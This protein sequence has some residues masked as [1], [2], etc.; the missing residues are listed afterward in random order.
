MLGFNIN[1][2]RKWALKFATLV[3]VMG[4]AIFSNQCKQ[5]E[6]DVSDP[7]FDSLVSK[8]KADLKS[9]ADSALKS[10]KS[11]NDFAL[12]KNNSAQQIEAAFLRGKAFELSGNNDSA[13]GY[14]FSMKGYAQRTQDTAQLLS[15]YNAIG[16]LY[17]EMGSNDTVAYWLNIGLRLAE[18]AGD[19]V[20]QACFS[21]NIGLYQMKNNQLDSAMHAFTRAA[22]FFEKLHDSA[23]IAL[24]YRN[25]GTTLNS[26]KLARKA[27]PFFK[28]AVQI[29]KKRGN[30][31]EVAAEY[32]NM[33]IAYKLID[34]D[35]VK[36]FYQQ[37]M[38]L[39][40]ESGSISNLM[41]IKFNYANYLKRQ[42]KIAEAEKLYKEVLRISTDNHILM[43]QLYGLNLLAKTAV[44]RNDAATANEYFD[45]ALALAQNN[46]LT[47]EILRLY[48]D[49]FEGSLSLRNV[50]KAT[51]YF[52]LWNNLNDSLQTTAQQDAVVKYQTL[53][54]T[55][56]KNLEIRYLETEREKRRIRTNYLYS[57]FLVSLLA[58]IAS[59]YAL[60]LKGKNTGQK[61][62]IAGQTHKTLQLEIA[63]KELLLV[64]K[65][66]EQAIA[67]KEAE[68]NQKLV[69]SKM[70][71]I[72][73]NSEFLS[74]ILT[75]LQALNFK[76]DTEVQQESMK[77]ILSSIK[78]QVHTKRW[79]DFQQQYLEAHKDF[80]AKLNETHPGLTSGEHRLCAMLR[81]NLSIKEISEL[82]MQNHRAVEMAR[83]RLRNKFNLEREEN[84]VAYL[85]QF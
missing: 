9:D 41:M 83:H 37:A 28:Q 18:L 70:L 60:W 31:I 84:L 38:K 44:I 55:E 73:H 52:N 21:S 27:I 43:G 57:I 82:T 2:K 63:N 54:E 11:L 4:M 47:G 1:P 76:L 45:R 49:I 22:L 26:Q 85:S 79:D 7:V 75:E 23:N 59:M 8:V 74:A 5:P 71:I 40:D 6:K 69:V 25:I 50:E 16:N 80:F 42:G 39:L 29:N 78:C 46:K 12:S 14:Y 34:E 30:N 58:A 72:S 35:S 81:M 77:K 33:A 66:Q 19:S 13:L 10:S 3:F 36:F 53:Y 15:A 65:E 62:F 48:L 32:S 20:K 17:L 61:L 67:K 68:A 56:K 24:V 64:S 51:T